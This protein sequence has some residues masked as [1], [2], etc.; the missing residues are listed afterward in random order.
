MARKDH[1][2]LATDAGQTLHL[3]WDYGIPYYMDPISGVDVDIRRE[4]GVNQIGETPKEQRVGGIF[5][6]IT[7]RFVH[8]DAQARSFINALPYKTAGTMYFLDE[9]FC[10]FLIHKTP[11]VPPDQG[12]L[13]FSM[14]A[15]SPR[16]YWQRI[17][18]E[19]YVLGGYTPVFTFPSDFTS[20]IF[21]VKNPSAFVNVR[22]PGALPVPLTCRIVAQ[23]NAVAPVIANPI[24]GAYIKLHTALQQGDTVDVY[25]DTADKVAVKL[26]RDGRETNIFADLDWRSNLFELAA[27][28]NVLRVD[29]DSGK[30]NLQVSISFYPAY[31]GVIPDAF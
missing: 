2:I 13:H 23:D 1:L 7:G 30:D 27:G 15:F 20:Y 6:T 16:P 26:I 31:T 4:Q 24:T 9:Y 25:R 11:Y 18:S 8:G 10:R 3:G 5:R 14:M 28:D 19:E 21:G 29:A 12:T 22:N 17:K